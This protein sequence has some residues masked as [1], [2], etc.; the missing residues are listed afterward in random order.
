MGSPHL[1]VHTLTA[2][3]RRS[4]DRHGQT[5]HCRDGVPTALVRPPVPTL[6]ITCQILGPK[7]LPVSRPLVA[8]APLL[9]RLPRFRQH[10]SP[11]TQGLTI[12]RIELQPVSISGSAGRF[13]TDQGVRLWPIDHRR[14]RARVCS[15]GSQV[16]DCQFSFPYAASEG[17]GVR[18]FCTG[19]SRLRSG[20]F[21]SC[22]HR[23]GPQPPEPRA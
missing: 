2:E 3:L 19:D 20:R 9:L 6:P 13:A 18:L 12:Y 15:P 10:P 8:D 4:Q 1:G 5:R 16:L 21:H 7:Q 17:L 22:R 11:E 14:R 23:E